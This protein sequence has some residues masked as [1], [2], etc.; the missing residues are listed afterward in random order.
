MTNLRHPGLRV[1]DIRKIISCKRQAI[2]WEQGLD[3]R[4]EWVFALLE[5]ELYKEKFLVWLLSKNIP[6]SCELLWIDP[7]YSEVQKM[8]W[9]EIV[10][11]LE[12]YFGTYAFHLYDIDLKWV[13]EY[14]TTQVARFGRISEN[15]NM[16]Q[17]RSLIV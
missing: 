11:S 2:K 17:D 15:A 10:S 9:G 8:R 3:A 1:R 12:H 6:L 14:S 5:N 7:S 4:N 16:R 13:L